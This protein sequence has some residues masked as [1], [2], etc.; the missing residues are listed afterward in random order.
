MSKEVAVAQAPQ[1][2]QQ[3]APQL[4]SSSEDTT[5]QQIQEQVARA[6]ANQQSPGYIEVKVNGKPRRFTLEEAKAYVTKAAAA[7][8][9]FQYAAE[10]DKKNKAFEQQ[11][12]QDAVK[13]LL[14]R[15]VPMEKIR[16]HFERWYK[17]EIIDREAMDPK[18]RALVDRQ[19]QLEERERQ[20]KEAEEQRQRQEQ[21]ALLE[22]ERASLHQ[23]LF[24]ALEKSDLPKSRFTLARAAYWIKRNAESQFDAP[25][26]VVMQQVKNERNE[27]FK[28]L[29]EA[30][31]GEQLIDL[32]GDQVMKKLYQAAL[33]KRSDSKTKP[34][35]KTP[36]STR[37]RKAE[38]RVYMDDVD[39][40][41]NRL[42][43]GLPVE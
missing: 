29:S 37:T 31:S 6:E 1:Q 9:R 34:L 5:N 20:I 14:Q 2:M 18:E 38:Q 22:K 7:D 21:E 28:S 39:Y 11:L 32:M 10:I 25:M 27:I 26:D 19:R 41:L 42:R 33:A 12:E 40:R 17:T 35:E 4:S 23:E 15:G 24:Q 36:I 3:Q 30:L 8:E 13:A 16:E 43:R